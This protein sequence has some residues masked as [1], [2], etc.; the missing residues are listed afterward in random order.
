M[1]SNNSE[2]AMFGNK[3]LQDE[4]INPE[5]LLTYAWYRD[6]KLLS[7]VTVG[8]HNFYK[9]FTVIYKA[10]YMPEDSN[11]PD[12]MQL[13]MKEIVAYLCKRQNAISLR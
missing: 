1:L 9:A 4:N 8:R 11:W 7:S 12:L 13:K 6:K 3:E 5:K 10:D 2:Q